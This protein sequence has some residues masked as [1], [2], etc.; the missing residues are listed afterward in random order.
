MELMSS[1]YQLLKYIKGNT[2]K[3]DTVFCFGFKFFTLAFNINN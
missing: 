3:I 1:D 2:P